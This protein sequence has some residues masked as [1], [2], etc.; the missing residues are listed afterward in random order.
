MEGNRLAAGWALSLSLTGAG[1]GLGLPSAPRPSA[2]T[3]LD[4]GRRLALHRYPSLTWLRCSGVWRAQG[5]A[6]ARIAPRRASAEPPAARR[7]VA[8]NEMV[9]QVQLGPRR[10]QL[11]LG[12]GGQCCA[13]GPTFQTHPD[14]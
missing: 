14:L 5:K 10:R 12:E 3:G 6:A 7:R 4:S 8:A 11:A 1:E 13:S 9:C 2:A